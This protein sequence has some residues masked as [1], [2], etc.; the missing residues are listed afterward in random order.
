MDKQSLSARFRSRRDVNLRQF[1]MNAPRRGEALRVLDLGGRAN[2][3]QRVGLDFLRAQKV[4]V[5]IL[6]LSVE[7]QCVLAEG[8]DVL[9]YIVGDACALTAADDSYDVCH[10][11][12]VIEH[13]GLSREMESFA[14]EVR[15][16]APAYYIQSPNFWFPVDPHFWKL[17]GFHWLP[18]AAR[19]RLLTYLPLAHSGRAPDLAAAYRAAD[20]S[21]MLGKAQM[22]YLFPDAEL[23]A[24]RFAGLF[25]KSYTAIRAG[26]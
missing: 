11:N 13:V 10:A 4:R 14:A 17:P 26:R 18:R 21:N 16:V 6:N 1:L 19:A 5:D 24:E 12:S 25:A 9:S 8:G 3:W 7:E 15:R 23:V 22:R 20:S 2:Y